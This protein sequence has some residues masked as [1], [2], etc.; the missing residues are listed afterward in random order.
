MYSQNIQFRDEDFKKAS[1]CGPIMGCAEVAI[2]NGEAVA[3]RNSQDLHKQL[4]FTAK[5]WKIFIAG[6]KNGEFDI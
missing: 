4:S 6:V 2:K 1:V 5:E 3:M